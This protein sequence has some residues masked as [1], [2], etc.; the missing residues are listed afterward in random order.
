MFQS[1]SN[2]GRSLELMTFS[3]PEKDLDRLYFEAEA[4]NYS[5]DIRAGG[6]YI[7]MRV[8]KR[9]RDSLE[10]TEYKRTAKWHFT[11]MVIEGREQ[12]AERV[13]EAYRLPAKYLLALGMVRSLRKI[14]ELKYPPDYLTGSTNLHMAR[15]LFKCGFKVKG[16]K[17]FEDFD[18]SQKSYAFKGLTSEAALKGWLERLDIVYDRLS[19]DVRFED[20]FL[21][22]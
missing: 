14:G 21:S 10:L 5:T 4:Y 19:K 7:L 11:P 13:E 20:R 18:E 9:S 8:H 22:V 16:V 17:L 6:L 2:Y 12:L 1:E 15:E 3:T